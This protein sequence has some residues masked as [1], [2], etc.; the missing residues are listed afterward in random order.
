MEIGNGNIRRP[1][2]H[3]RTEIPKDMTSH[4]VIKQ[5]ICHFRMK[6]RKASTFFYQIRFVLKEDAVL[7]SNYF[8]AWV[9]QPD[10]F[11]FL[12]KVQQFGEHLLS[13]R[14]PIFLKSTECISFVHR[15]KNF[16]YRGALAE[17]DTLKSLS[18]RLSG[19]FH[20]RLLLLTIFCHKLNLI[21][22]KQV[23]NKS[24]QDKL[25]TKLYPI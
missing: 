7:Y 17:K 11:G 8:S 25:G 9:I 16:S 21:T 22:K 10:R 12:V 3:D 6:F 24:E 23:S 14:F 5:P 2:T 20:R 18:W 1:L 15:E 13:F 4:W 19:D